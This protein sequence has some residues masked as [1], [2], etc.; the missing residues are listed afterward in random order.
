M[1]AAN[2]KALGVVDVA[3]AA[4]RVGGV[5]QPVGVVIAVGDAD[6]IAGLGLRVAVVIV[7]VTGDRAI[8]RFRLQTVA[9][10][11]DQIRS[12]LRVSVCQARPTPAGHIRTSGILGVSKASKPQLPA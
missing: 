11:V 8:D 4:V 12:A 7:G 3:G 1:R 9:A 10:V 6:A 2:P 5:D